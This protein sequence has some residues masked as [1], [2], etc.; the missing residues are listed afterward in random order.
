[1]ILGETFERF[2]EGSPVTVMVRVLLEQSLPQHDIDELF[3]QHA[4]KQY[5]YELLFSTVVNLMSLVVCGIYPSVN[6]AYQAK[7]AD[8]EVSVTSVYNKL[9]GLEPNIGVALVHYVAQQ[10]QPIIDQLEGDLPALLPGYRAKILDG[11]HLSSTQHRLEVLR[12]IGSAPLPGHALVILDP[13]LMLVIDAFACED[14]YAQERSVLGL[15]LAT[16]VSGDLW[17]GD[18]NFCTL[19]FLFG[20]AGR[21]ASFVIRQ[22][23]NLPWQA[24]DELRFIG[25]SDT[26]Q[27]FEQPIQLKHASGLLLRIRRVVVQLNQPTRDGEWN[28]AVLSNLPLGAANALK[29]AE[30]YQKRWT[31]ERLFQVL[32]QN[33]EGEIN[34]LAYPR[35]ALFGF[36]M[37]LVA[38]NILSVLKA[39]LRSVHGSGKIEAGLSDYYLAG[40]IRRIYEGMMIAIPPSQ[41][42]HL[43]EMEPSQT[44]QLLQ[45]LAAHIN[46]STLRSHPRGPKKTLPKRTHRKDKPH[47]STARLLAENRDVKSGT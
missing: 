47:V 30:L 34:T 1:M 7:A 33:F 5:T 42:H 36:C 43:T 44:A 10:M 14:A 29:V 37:A 17:L 9:N 25:N 21:G 28:I 4:Q 13:R 35:A 20:I 45:E 6:A 41:W 15:V 46:L 26:G 19:D 23:G 32:E 22:H 31:L 11:N 40:E 24:V 8:M 18:R 39:A 38:Y 12:D 3:E 27:V 16:I 2:I